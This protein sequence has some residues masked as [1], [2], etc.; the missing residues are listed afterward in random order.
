MSG[1][2]CLGHLQLFEKKKKK[3][4]VWLYCSTEKWGT[5]KEGEFLPSP[6]LDSNLGTT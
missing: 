5:G 2:E 6:A 3:D 1:K 4:L